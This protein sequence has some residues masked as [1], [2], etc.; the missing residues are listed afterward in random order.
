MRARLRRTTSRSLLTVLISLCLLAWVSKGVAMFVSVDVA[1]VPVERVT[2]NIEQMLL[3]TPSD[4]QLKINLA[5]VHM[6]A[7]ALKRP[8][9]AVARGRETDGPWPG[10][11]KENV[12]PRPTPT[13]NAA[14]NKEA[15]NHLNRALAIYE[16]VVAQVPDHALAR[17]GYAWSLQMSGQRTQAVQAY[18]NAVRVAWPQDRDRKWSFKGWRSI[19]GEAARYLIPLLDPERDKAEIA[20]LGD[21]MAQ[22][23]KQARAITPIVIPLRDDVSAVDLV[24][25]SA[26]VPFDLDG[27]GLPKRWTWITPDAAWLV[28]DR[29]HRGAIR[30]GLQLFGNVTFWLFWEN[31]YSAL[32]TLDDDGDGRLRGQELVGLALWRD[33]D[34]DGISD[35]GEV[36]ALGFWGITEL[37]CRYQHDARHPDEIAFSPTGVRFADGRTR[38]TYDVVLRQR[39]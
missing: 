14:K 31:G 35:R 13:T 32:Q 6:M 33:A 8:T 15:S 28:M 18:R 21:Y 2:R 23:E 11:L 1:E 24:D 38:A 25:E 34:R 27:S 3:K 39:R 17:L 19:T 9:V 5:R 12:L 26:N 29:H 36:Q 7:F 22:L 37:S 4:V 10:H 16:E 20:T 30:S